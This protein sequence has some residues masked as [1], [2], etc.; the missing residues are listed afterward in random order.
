VKQ[1]KM[2]G[3]LF[4]KWNDAAVTTTENNSATCTTHQ[5]NLTIPFFVFVVFIS[6]FCAEIEI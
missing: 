3:R 4:P 2:L 6:E 5:T 1:E